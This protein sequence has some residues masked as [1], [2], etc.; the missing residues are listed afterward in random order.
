MNDTE[1]KT[2]EV[3]RKMLSGLLPQKRMQMAAEMFSTARQIVIA[4]LRQQNLTEKQIRLQLFKR[5]YA[6]DF[7][8]EEKKQILN[9]LS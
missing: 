9:H 8:E 3:Y 4:S 5:F 6:A 7:S 2:E 1:K